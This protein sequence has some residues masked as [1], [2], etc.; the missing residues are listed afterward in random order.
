MRATCPIS[1]N[2]LELIMLAEEYNA[3]SS[4]LYDFLLSPA[5]SSLLDPNIF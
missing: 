3:R 2:R 5:V 4:A 1:L